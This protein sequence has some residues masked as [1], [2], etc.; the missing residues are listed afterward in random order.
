MVQ[1]IAVFSMTEDLFLDLLLLWV[2]GWGGF[3]VA[4]AF[5]VT[6]AVLKDGQF[7]P[8]VFLQ[9]TTIR[10]FE[11]KVTFSCFYRSLFNITS[12]QYYAVTATHCCN[13]Y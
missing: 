12:P 6:A 4:L 1:L 3:F 2:Q 9:F 8:L 7:L 11:K 5:E 13:C 10:T